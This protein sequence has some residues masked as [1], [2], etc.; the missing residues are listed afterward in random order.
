MVSS[1]GGPPLIRDVLAAIPARAKLSVFLVQHT[2]GQGTLALAKWLKQTTALKVGIA[3]DGEPVRDGSVYLAP[4]GV[5]LAMQDR[6]IALSDAPPIASHKP[7]GDVLLRSLAQECAP[8]ELVAMVLTGMGA[9]GASGLAAAAS[10]GALTVVQAPD[11]AVISG[12][13]HRALEAAP[14]SLVLSPGA[15]VELA[16][17]AGTT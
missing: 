8:E 10:A 4:D 6:R 12:M 2:T 1:T 7:S 14:A 5:H 16:R 9:D 13:P 11:S 17:K 3:I 15:L